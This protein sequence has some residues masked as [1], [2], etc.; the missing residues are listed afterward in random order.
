MGLFGPVVEALELPPPLG[1]DDR[2]E[3]ETLVLVELL[4]LALPL[5]ALPPVVLFDTV[6]LPDVAVW[7][8]VLVTVTLLLLV[9]EVLL[10]LL[11]VTALFGPVVL[12]LSAKAIGA[13]PINKAGT[14][15]KIVISLINLG[16]I[17]PSICLS[18]QCPLRRP[19]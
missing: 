6:A 4:L 16:R 2:L 18:G 17:T 14:N 3:I 13:A 12:R 10:L 5:V 9:S 11:T 8:L 19:D 15:P 7:E 1:K